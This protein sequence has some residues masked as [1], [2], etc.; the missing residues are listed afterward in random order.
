MSN[1]Y[2]NDFNDCVGA[3][4]NNIK[5]NKHKSKD[6]ELE[7]ISK[8][9]NDIKY[10]NIVLE[11][12]LK[13]VFSVAKK[14]RGRGVDME[15]LISEGNMGLIRAIESFDISKDV[16]F[17]SYAVFWIKA[18]IENF[19]KRKSFQTEREIN[20]DD[21]DEC[22]EKYFTE[23]VEEHISNMEQFNQYN[24]QQLLSVLTERER[25]IMEMYFGINGDE[26]TLDDIGEVLEISK[27]RVRQCKVT[28]IRK[29]RNELM[30]SY[31]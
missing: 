16:K 4:Y 11:S 15:D 24:V 31:H 14:Y 21:D 27:E 6:E 13:F 7:L 9:K 23:E 3:Y 1:K 20:V 28:A 5:K 25:N 22:K 12:N 19:I 2:V 26:M 10:R 17:I 18:Y 8:A 29:M 30:L